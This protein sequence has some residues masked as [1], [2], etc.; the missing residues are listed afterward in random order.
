LMVVFGFGVSTDVDNLS[1]AVLDRDQSSA[2]LAY[3]G[4]L[5]G[6]SYFTEKPPITSYAHRDARLQSGTVSAVIEIPPGFGRDIKRGRPAF[7][8][9][10]ID[11]AMPFRAQT[12]RG[13]LQAVQA[14]YLARLI[15]RAEAQAVF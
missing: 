2:S 7:I 13:Y 4:E 10:T 9:A 15:Q 8:S 6:S 12:I 11:G 14:I 1:F 5:R 3:L